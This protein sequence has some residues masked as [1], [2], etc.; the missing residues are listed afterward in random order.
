MRAFDD[1]PNHRPPV[2]LT[3]A[4]YQ[5]MTPILILI[6]SP[7]LPLRLLRSPFR[8]Q[9]S[10]LQAATGQEMDPEALPVVEVLMQ[11]VMIKVRFH[12]YEAS[13]V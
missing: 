2:L 9:A 11:P 3:I 4:V 6:A 8:A 7:S 13:P 1:P 12:Q 10:E 5:A